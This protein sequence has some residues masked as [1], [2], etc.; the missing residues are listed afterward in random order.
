MDYFED[1]SSFGIEIKYSNH[2][3]ESGTGGAFKLAIEN[4]FHPEHLDHNFLAKYNQLFK[5]RQT[6]YP[7]KTHYNINYLW[8]IFLNPLSS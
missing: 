3:L 1:G 8:K 5:E 6:K 7:K 4:G 2:K